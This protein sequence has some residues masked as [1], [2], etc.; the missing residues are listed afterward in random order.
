MVRDKA[1]E[2]KFGDYGCYNFIN[3]LKLPL[4]RGHACCEHDII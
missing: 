2:K 1:V 4:D 3:S